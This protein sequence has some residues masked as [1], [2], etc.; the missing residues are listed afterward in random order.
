MR[1]MVFEGRAL[2]SISD[3]AENNLG[4]FLNGG[5]RHLSLYQCTSQMWERRYGYL[6]PSFRHFHISIL[7]I[8][9]K[10][11]SYPVMNVNNLNAMKKK[12]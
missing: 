12:L 11:M 1:I 5:F 3:K 6:S 7:Y 4:L 9:L 10:N 2:I 8:I